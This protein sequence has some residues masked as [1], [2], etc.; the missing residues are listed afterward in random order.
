MKTFTI[1]LLALTVL[2]TVF[3]ANSVLAEKKKQLTDCEKEE[4]QQQGAT[5]PNCVEELKRQRVRP[6]D[7]E[8]IAQ[9]IW[10]GYT[11]QELYEQGYISIEQKRNLE[12]ERI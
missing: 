3:K 5:S 9:M 12:S 4:I 10:E 6:L 1:T 7:R 11:L 2:S 8:T